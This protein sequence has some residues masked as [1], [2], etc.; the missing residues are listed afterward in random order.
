MRSCPNRGPPQIS[1][2]RSGGN[3]QLSRILTD[4]EFFENGKASDRRFWDGETRTQLVL[5]QKQTEK[6]SLRPCFSAPSREPSVIMTND[7]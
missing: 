4:M 6:H 3:S 1:Q 2:D 5:T 7:Y